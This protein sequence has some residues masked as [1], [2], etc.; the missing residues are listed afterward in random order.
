L[1]WKCNEKVLQFDG[2]SVIIMNDKRLGAP[3]TQAFVVYSIRDVFN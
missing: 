3:L 1:Q 2:I